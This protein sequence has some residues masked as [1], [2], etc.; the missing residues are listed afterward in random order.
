MQ[1]D[2]CF[3]EPSDQTRA[4]L[5]RESSS[6]ES[7]RAIET[8]AVKVGAAPWQPRSGKGR[9]MKYCYR[10]SAVW[11]CIATVIALPR[12]GQRRRWARP[13]ESNV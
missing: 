12:T 2:E 5:T 8:P 1:H 9:Y 3:G 13:L 11:S 6:G 7:A 10:G 4:C